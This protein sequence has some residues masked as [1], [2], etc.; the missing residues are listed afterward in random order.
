MGR[1]NGAGDARPAETQ[2][3]EGTAF[4]AATD[5][6]QPTATTP[7]PPASTPAPPSATP[8]NASQPLVRLSL[9]A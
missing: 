8:T 7:A 4:L 3:M 6:S 1:V 9:S 2:Q 5:A